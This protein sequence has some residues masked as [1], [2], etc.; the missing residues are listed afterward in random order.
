MIIGVERELNMCDWQAMQYLLPLSMLYLSS[1]T[2]PAGNPGFANRKS[3]ASI[4]KLMCDPNSPTATTSSASSPAS[5]LFFSATAFLALTLLSAP[6]LRRSELMKQST[7]L[8]VLPATAGVVTMP[9]NLLMEMFQSRADRSSTLS[10]PHTR[11]S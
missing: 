10:S 3:D 11:A 9:R 7:V 8:S 2:P 5:S 6:I 4:Q 1:C